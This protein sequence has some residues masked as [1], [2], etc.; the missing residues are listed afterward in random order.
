MQEPTINTAFGYLTRSAGQ[1]VITDWRGRT[2]GPARITN[3]WATPRSTISPRMYTIEAVL[4]GVTFVGRC[5]GLAMAWKGRPK[6]V[7]P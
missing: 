7:R 2:L 6:S 5:S 4:D 1:L 3:S